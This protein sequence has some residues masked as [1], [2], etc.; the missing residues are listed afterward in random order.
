MLRA[1]V[2]RRPV[3]E[4][5]QP[6]QGAPAQSVQGTV[7][8]V[9]PDPVIGGR[10][11]HTQGR[12]GQLQAAHTGQAR[13]SVFWRQERPPTST[14]PARTQLCLPIGYRLLT[15]SERCPVV[16]FARCDWLQPVIGLDSS[17]SDTKSGG[18]R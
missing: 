4:A 16:C 11:R 1:R 18:W 17:G 15:A 13:P 3:Q 5:P 9:R 14:F 6:A 8:T 12:S 7:I 10:E 2:D